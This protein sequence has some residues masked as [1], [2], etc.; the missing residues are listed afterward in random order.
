MYALIEASGVFSSCE[1]LATKS[2][3]IRSSRRS[4][5]TSWKTSTAPRGG[6]PGSGVPWTERVRACGLG[7]GSRPARVIS[8]R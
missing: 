5:V 4:S 6:G 8:P 1:T 2:W 7:N 3:R